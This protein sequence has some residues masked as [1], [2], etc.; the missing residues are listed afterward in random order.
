MAKP[1]NEWELVL[2]NR[3]V[4]ANRH[5]RFV[6][7]ITRGERG[8]G[9]SMYNL[10]VM[11]YVHHVL[12][13]LSEEDAWLKALDNI[14]FSPYDYMKRIAYN[15][16]NDIVDPVWCLDDAGVHFTGMMFFR[17]LHLY[18]LVNGSFDTIRTV[19][20]SL[21]INC[22]Y[23]KKLMSGLQQYDDREITLYID[24]SAENG[25][26]KYGRK[27]VC[28][29]WYRLPSGKREW[30]KDFE[31]L[32]SCYVPKWIYTK[33]LLKRKKFNKLITDEWGKHIDRLES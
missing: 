33:Y 1:I 11:A 4:N 32:F 20:N 8:Y 14:I 28:I 19:T 13:G 5:N 6:S 29:K 23:K 31:D 9:K 16:D 10:K 27:A 2:G 17:S 22:P 25:V 21:L 24:T 30:Y 15:Y 3:L 18:A 7:V 12:Y 26:G